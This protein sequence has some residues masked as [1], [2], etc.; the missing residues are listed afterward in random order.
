MVVAQVGAGEEGEAGFLDPGSNVGG[1]PGDAGRARAVG[2]SVKERLEASL[3]LD[4]PLARAARV[5]EL[6]LD[7]SPGNVGEVLLLMEAGPRSDMDNA[8]FREFLTAWARFD[9]KAALDYARGVGELDEG[10][11]R[12][13]VRG[14]DDAVMREWAGSEPDAAIGYLADLDAGRNREELSHAVVQGLADQDFDL[15][16]EVATANSRSRARGWSIGLLARKKVE[17]G[18]VEGVDA[19]LRS[20]DPETT[21]GD[22]I[23]SFKRAAFS[24]AAERFARNDPEAAAAW[25]QTHMGEDY[26]DSRAY[27]EIA[28]RIGGDDRVAR[29]AWLSE[30]PAGSG[31]DEALGNTVRRWADDDPLGA[32]EW[33]A[34]QPLD[35]SFDRAK[36]SLA[37]EVFREDPAAAMSWSQAI[38]DQGRQ[39]RTLLRLGREWIR[40]DEAAAVNWLANSTLPQEILAPLARMLGDDDT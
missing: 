36:Y 16:F 8:I 27:Y 12:R 5:T 35:A 34:S 39:N 15:A 19:W 40:R 4:D 6:L 30:L 18:G 29:A 10:R 25:L 2:G 22:E 24:E 21:E 33:L 20:I 14:G 9:G 31:R 26:V 13:R 37:R 11:D 1:G 23:G 7:L 38:T 17:E 3:A 28:Q 32:S